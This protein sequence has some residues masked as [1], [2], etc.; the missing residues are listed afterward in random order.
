MI[1]SAGGDLPPSRDHHRPDA[2][3]A[4]QRA[5]GQERYGPRT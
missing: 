1:A 2:L 5:T 3:V 4:R